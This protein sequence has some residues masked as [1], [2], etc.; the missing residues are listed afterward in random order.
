MTV[1][2]ELLEQR[3]TKN[4]HEAFDACV[5]WMQT[6]HLPVQLMDVEQL[7]DG[8]TLIFYFLGDPPADLSARRT[9]LVPLE[10]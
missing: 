5:S 8:Q 4:R 7:F 10:A 3:L 2:D 9:P 6:E 1:E